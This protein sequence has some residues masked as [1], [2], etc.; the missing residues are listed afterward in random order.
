MSKSKTYFPSPTR[1]TN[2]SYYLHGLRYLLF[3]WEYHKEITDHFRLH[4]AGHDLPLCIQMC[5]E[6][7]HQLVEIVC[8]N[9]GIRQYYCIW[10]F[11]PQAPITYSCCMRLSTWLT[12]NMYIFTLCTFLIGLSCL[13]C[14]RHYIW[15]CCNYCVISKIPIRN[16]CFLKKNIE[17]RGVT[18]IPY[19]W[20]VTLYLQDL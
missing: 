4:V 2:A 11:N 12:F 19:Q 8:C 9:G 3:L 7:L 10:A 5:M 17:V 14:I 13:D 6:Y 20:V 16:F 1:I 15:H 18:Y